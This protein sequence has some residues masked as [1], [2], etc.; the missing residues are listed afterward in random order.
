MH[1]GFQR[2]PLSMKLLLIGIIPLAFLVYL[3]FQVY[4]EKTQKLTLLDGYI[5]RID[6]SATIN[7]LIDYLQ[8]ERKLSFDLA[9]K[10]EGQAELL[11]QRPIID[12]VMRELEKTTIAG[13]TA[14]TFLH[15][16]KD[17]RGL[18]DSGK[19]AP[20]QV[21][22]YYTTSIYRLNTLHVVSP[23]SEIFLELVYKDLIAQKLLSELSTSLGIIR[24]NVY[25]VLHTRKYML[26]TLIGMV[27]VNDIF[28]TYEIE[29][30]Q[31]A[32]PAAI[33]KYKFVRN[34]TDL[35]PTMDYLDTLFKRFSFD[36]TYTAEEWWR[37]S[38]NGANQLASVQ[39]M[40]ADNIVKGTKEIL[41]IEKASR[42]R[43]VIFLIG[44]LVFIIA[45]VIYTIYSITHSL[46]EMEVAAQDIAKGAPAPPLH[47][48]SNDTMGSLAGSILQIDANNKTLADAADAIGKGDF[49]VPIRP[50]SKDDILGNALVQMKANLQIQ[51]A[52]GQEK[53]MLLAQL[54]D[55]YKTVFYNSPIP[56][57]I[58]DVNTLKFLEVNEAALAHYGYS[59]EEFLSMSIRDIRPPEELDILNKN[60]EEIKSGEE[61]EQRLWHHKKKN[62]QVIVVEVKAY[63]IDYQD[64]RARMVV[65]NDVTDKIE[66]DVQLKKSH[67]EFRQLASHLQNI[68]EE[69]RA[70]MARE[71]HDVLGQQI[72]CIKMDV[73]WLTRHMKDEDRVVSEKIKSVLELIDHTA[74][75]V[76]KIASE[77][78]PSILDDFGLAEALEWQSQEFEKRSQVKVT[79]ISDVS[80]T[81]PENI[82]IG[83]FRVYQ[84]SLTNIARHAMASNVTSSLKTENNELVL[85]ISDDGKG[86]DVQA[87]GKKKTLGLLGMKER[88]AML[89]GKYEINSSQGKGTTVTIRIPL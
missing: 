51:T 11:R 26:E 63:F 44:A 43:A 22:H 42:D 18:V 2:L 87:A 61:P 4:Q 45:I 72:T 6:Q 33:A 28:K 78:R 53:T 76:R 24:S 40:V 25:N 46:K 17:I 74:V 19:I 9:M 84:E 73:S 35:K 88:T 65:I 38:D 85:T 79:F 49:D 47:I 29:F 81:I 50:R 30:L 66:S 70:S 59:V 5:R 37:V 69:E 56:K 34:E 89:G 54:A 16:L 68:R 82:K 52:S 55:K 60:I 27:G 41:R 57:W 23:G 20:D 77:L 8:K 36:S 71:V 15:K 48:K 86:F 1:R 80:A 10:K 21:M 13:Y 75:T 64:R 83:L 7:T 67:E 58:Y 14:Y 31:R 39:K 32:L 3:S 12:S 62:G